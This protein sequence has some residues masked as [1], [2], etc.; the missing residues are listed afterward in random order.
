MG[1]L[2]FP[3]LFDI[4]GHFNLNFRVLID[5]LKIWIFPQFLSFWEFQ[6]EFSSTF[7][8]FGTFNLNFPALLDVLDIWIFPQFLK[9]WESQFPFSRTFWHFRNINLNFPALFCWAKP[10]EKS[11]GK[12]KFPVI[13]KAIF[14]LFFEVKILILGA[15]IHILLC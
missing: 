4:L 9:F 5:I 15:K 12:F 1:S 14:A 2:N 7:W 11:A 13:Y 6:F 3:A 10:E 8:D